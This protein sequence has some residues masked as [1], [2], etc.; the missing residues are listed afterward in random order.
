[1]EIYEHNYVPENNSL[2]KN[3]ISKEDK[4][5][6]DFSFKG[7]EVVH[8]AFFSHLFEPSIKLVKETVSV[9]TACIRRMPDTEY[10]QFLVNRDEKKLVIKP[11]LE[12]TRDSFRWS[13][14]GKNG[15]VKPRTISCEKF[16]AKIMKLMD[17]DPDLRYRIMGKLI[18]T[19]DMSIFVF[20]LKE[21][22]KYK[23]GGKAEYPD[24]WGESFGVLA[25]EH[26]KDGLVNFCENDSVFYMEKGEEETEKNVERRQPDE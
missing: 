6:D 17:W 20:D 7:Y 26:E 24:G 16:F 25:D 12:E 22:E 14:V 19:K 21:P 23:R 2:T 15:K 13:S 5:Y 1:M 9:N 10:V 11:C 18:R 8:A 4:G 3:D